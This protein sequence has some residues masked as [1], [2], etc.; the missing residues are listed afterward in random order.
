MTKD[1]LHLFWWLSK[2]LALVFIFSG[3]AFASNWANN[4]EKPLLECGSYNQCFFQKVT[5]DSSFK[6]FVTLLFL[7]LLSEAMC[8]YLNSII[9]RQ[10]MNENDIYQVGLQRVRNLRR[11]SELEGTRTQLDIMKLQEEIKKIEK[12]LED[13]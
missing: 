2:I 3:G 7:T 5:N 10:K 4:F 1:F 12:D 9:E 13:N 11:N 6:P 8:I